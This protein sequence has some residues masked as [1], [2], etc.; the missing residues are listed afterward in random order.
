MAVG[1]SQRV[2]PE[3]GAPAGEAPFCASCG[4]NLASQ[5]RLPT[6]ADWEA[7]QR[8]EGAPAAAASSHATARPRRAKVWAAGGL[9]AIVVVAALL[10][11]GGGGST[12]TYAVPSESMEPTYEVGEKVTVNL[13]AYN[14]S[15][16]AAG[17]VVVFHPP[18]GAD[19]GTECGIQ[20]RVGEPCA[21]PTGGE[22]AQLF[23]KRIVA[24]PGDTLSIQD[25]HPV[26]NGELQAE[27][28][29]APCGGAGACNMPQTIT[30]APG[31]YF[32]LG[33]NRGASDDSRFWGPV[34]AA[35]IVGKVE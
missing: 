8:P 5:P 3:C 34:P 11:A 21:K 13:D 35:W 4:V 33:D 25:G 30:I 2:C 23:L 19:N 29:A 12:Q 6:R 15:E 1:S 20:P 17:D 9:A 16:P 28:F 24:G 7:A 18:A 10:L 31:E 27:P 32:M 26:V 14:S 22:S